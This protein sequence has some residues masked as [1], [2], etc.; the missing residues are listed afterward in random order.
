MSKPS[1]SFQNLESQPSLVVVASSR[2]VSRSSAA[3]F[4]T[5]GNRE[6]GE[7][8]QPLLAPSSS[9]QNPSVLFPAEARDF[10][11]DGLDELLTITTPK[12]GSGY[13]GDEMLAA[14]FDLDRTTLPKNSSG[15][16]AL[17]GCRR[18]NWLAVPALGRK[19]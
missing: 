7:G 6:N 8:L 5:G 2:H 9:V 12:T 11:G 14:G 15:E 3:P 1:A 10:D 13:R 18:P 17:L 4:R 19:H 16:D